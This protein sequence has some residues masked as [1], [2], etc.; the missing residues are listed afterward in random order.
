MY[1][2]CIYVCV[3]VSTKYIRTKYIYF[4]DSVCN[5]PPPSGISF[6]SEPAAA[7]FYRPSPSAEKSI[8]TLNSLTLYPHRDPQLMITGK[9]YPRAAPLPQVWVTLQFMLQSPLPVNQAMASLSEITLPLL[10]ALPNHNVHSPL[11]DVFLES[12]ALSKSQIP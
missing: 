5:D 11:Q 1:V 9:V 8:P 7:S 10:L 6:I 2:F 3:E 12:H 4:K